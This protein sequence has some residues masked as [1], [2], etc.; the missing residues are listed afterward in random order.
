MP[1]GARYAAVLYRRLIPHEGESAFLARE[2]LESRRGALRRFL[3]RADGRILPRLNKMLPA[4]LDVLFPGSVTVQGV[5][6]VDDLQIF[7]PIR[8]RMRQ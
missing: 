8:S 6:K 2:E 4:Q 5:I 1:S 3:P 7:C